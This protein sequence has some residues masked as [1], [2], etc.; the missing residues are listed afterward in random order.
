MSPAPSP[1]SGVSAL[2]ELRC[3]FS[4]ALSLGLVLACLS[5]AA[6]AA[7]FELQ[8]AVAAESRLFL[9]PARYPG[10]H[11]ANGSLALRPEFYW[12]WEE[13]A[14]SFSFAPFVRVDQGD[15]RRSHAD[16]RELTWLVAREAW[17]FRAG[18][19]RVFWGVA[20]SNHLVDIINQTDLV[21]N[22]DTEDKL[23]QPMLNLALIRDWGTVDL[24]VLPGFR[25][26][27]FPGKSGRLRTQPRVDS[28][29]ARYDSAAENKHV[30]FALR[31][32]HTVGG[33]DVGVY[34]FRGT[35]R[36]PRFMPTRTPSGEPV[37]AP[38][39]DQINQTGLDALYTWGSWLFK[40][41]A[42]NRTGQGEAFAAA[43][44]GFEYTFVGILGSALDLGVLAEYHY[45]ER[46]ERA[47][48]PFNRDLFAGFRLAL[49]DM[50]GTS[51]LAGVVS[52]LQGR[53][54]FFNVEASRRIGERWRIEAELRVFH[55][56]EAPDLLDFVA[57]DDYLGL[58]LGR[59]F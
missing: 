12:E 43:V 22:P 3:R 16:I 23:G 36:E 28:S 35:S 4:R 9:Q 33:L 47:L 8:G 18:V 7:D 15:S 2:C 26:R 17:E 40:L 42:L 37:L 21:E 24:F 13:G 59:Y 55:A 30:D 46:D 51:V 27:T 52:D 31:W 41:E 25:E 58:E 54:E 44:G 45:D 50:E 5:P 48:T 56:T 14:Q 29:S 6:G 11:G 34:H 1:P 10:Q 53:G 19:R 20:E 38:F 39:Y 32:S 49:N 57:R